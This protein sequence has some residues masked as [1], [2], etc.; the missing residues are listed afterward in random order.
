[1]L[2]SHNSDHGVTSEFLQYLNNINSK[3]TAWFA[4]NIEIHH[5][6]LHVLPI[7]IA[8]SQ[9]PH[10][11]IHAIR[12]VLDSPPPK[13]EFCYFYF[14]SSTAPSKR[15]RV[16][17]ICFSKGIAPSRASNYSTYIRHLAA[18]KFAICPEGNGIDTHR[19]W[20][21]LYLDVVP[22]VTRSVFIE[23]LKPFGLPMV[24][25]DDWNDLDKNLLEKLYPRVSK[26]FQNEVV[27][28]NM[29]NILALSK[30]RERINQFK[31]VC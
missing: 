16:E 23:M 17:E 21:C 5:L 10:G 19:L 27:I 9:W 26:D 22:I 11:D 25:L 14:N 1:V 31:A 2:L 18:H 28:N 24:V 29:N 3:I 20:E 13:T 30:I 12:A 7:G 4:Q 8:N 15:R 6:K